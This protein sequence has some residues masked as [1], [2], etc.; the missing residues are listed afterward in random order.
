MP[1]SSTRASFDTEQEYR[2]IEATLLETARG[3]WFLTEHSRRARR[4]DNAVLEDAITRLQGSLLQPPP[5][6][7][8]LRRDVEDLAKALTDARTKLNQPPAA[9]AGNGATART[10]GSPSTATATPVQ[11]ILKAAETMHEL[12]WSLQANDA[13]ARAC[14]G[15]ARQASQIYALSR[16]QALES[17]RV[18][19]LSRALDGIGARIT[20]ILETI[21]TELA[22]DTETKPVEDAITTA[23]LA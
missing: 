7:E 19:E 15:I 20:A 11:E 1:K 4:L 23:K 10:E 21:S 9:R 8:K 2:A 12:A 22:I 3:R 6:L 17:E 13:D 5:M 14:E 16:R 18:V